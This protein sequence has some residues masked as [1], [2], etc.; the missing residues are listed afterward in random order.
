MRWR[1][2]KCNLL[3]KEYEVLESGFVSI[4]DSE[5]EV[6]AGML[7]VEILHSSEVNIIARGRRYGRW[8]RLKGLTKQHRFSSVDRRQLQSEFELQSR[9]L[10][11]GV[12]Q[13]V[14]FEEID[15]LGG[16]IVEEWVEGRKLS[17]L[18]QEGKLTKQ[19]RRKIIREII[20]IV[21]YIHSRGVAHRNLN[22]SNIMVRDAGG[23]VVLNDFGL[24]D[25]DGYGDDIYSL[26]VIMKELCPEYGRI[27][28]RC[29]GPAKKRPKD[30]GKLLKSLDRHDRL[31]KVIWSISGVAV[32][33]VLGMLAVGYINSLIAVARADQEK[34]L[35]LTEL[36]RHQKQHV[37]HL[38]DSL[39]GVINRIN[40]TEDEIKGMDNY[41]EMRK[42]AYLATSKKIN[43]TLDDFEKN[44][45]PMFK[46][47]DVAFYDSI[48][49]L[50][51][52]LQYICNTAYTVKNIPVFKE[53][54]AYIFY[55]EAI[56]Y[57]TINFSKYYMVWLAK[58]RNYK[59]TEQG[60]PDLISRA[61]ALDSIVAEEEA[62]R[63]E[64]KKL[65]QTE[66]S[67]K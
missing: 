25:T 66:E 8:W 30:T 16:C 55:D 41:S 42:Q 14:G 46:G 7:D 31:P 56:G 67:E 59:L 52:K 58:L 33:V 18:L 40:R 45:F 17:E 34:I 15:G 24:A 62:K 21:G 51:K 57:Y 27:A 65:E 61:I 39:T 60:Q 47:Q 22:P 64:K 29:T 2:K 38:A 48:V 37:T 63:A 11:P 20:R 26:G 4:P 54:D 6:R 9:L 19:E 28:A 50:H 44:V 1:K 13:A 12:A 5:F 49:A 23:G 36:N 32:L 35:A 3:M 43:K 10:I 53:D